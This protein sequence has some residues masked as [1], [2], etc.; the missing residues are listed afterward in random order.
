[1]LLSVGPKAGCAEVSETHDLWPL[2]DPRQARKPLPTLPV[3]LPFTHKQRIGRLLDIAWVWLWC[4]CKCVRAGGRAGG[5]RYSADRLARRGRV[6]NP[7]AADPSFTSLQTTVPQDPQPVSRQQSE[8]GQGDPRHRA[9]GKC[10]FCWSRRTIM[11]RSVPFF[12]RPATTNSVG[13]YDFAGLKAGSHSDTEHPGGPT[14]TTP[15]VV[16]SDA[17]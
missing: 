16:I 1:M 17:R 10:R 5:I 14:I 13:I 3:S 15:E 9:I 6:L 7:L 11:I 4:A 8:L 12:L 2:L